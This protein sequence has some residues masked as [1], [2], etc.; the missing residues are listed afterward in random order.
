M[1]QTPER[2]AYRV[3]ELA[4]L[5]G[6]SVIAVRRMVDR[7]QIP[8]RRLGHR[9]VILAD[10]LDAFLK[11]LPRGALPRLNEPNQPTGRS[12]SLHDPQRAAHGPSG[13]RAPGARLAP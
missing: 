11:A 3:H 7:G 8:T 6:C 12:G 4:G 10:E 9:V 13:S 5:L 1:V 2:A